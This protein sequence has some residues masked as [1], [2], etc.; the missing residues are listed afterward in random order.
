MSNF[1]PT[2]TSY[3]VISIRELL[4]STSEKPAPL[5]VGNVFR[6][7]LTEP[8]RASSREPQGVILLL[9]LWFTMKHT[10]FCHPLA[11]AGSLFYAGESRSACTIHSVEVK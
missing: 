5:P 6:A 9:I 8:T 11:T 10:G 1:H 7:N 3:N 4:T 2:Q